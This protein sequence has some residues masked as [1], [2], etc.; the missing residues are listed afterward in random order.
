MKR[1]I[2]F[3]AA[4]LLA[5]SAQANIIELWNTGV[6]STGTSL[7]DGATD[8]HYTLTTK[9]AGEAGTVTVLTSAG[10]FPI[11]PWL[12][13]STISAWIGLGSNAKNGTYIYETTFDLTGL[14]PSTASISGRWSTDNDGIKILLNGVDTGAP[15]TSFTQFS[16]GY[17]TFTISS[18]FQPGVNTLAF[19]VNN[20]NA[21]YP[22]GSPTGVRVE[23]H[24]TAAPVPEPTTVIA[25]ALLL[26][27]FG[28]ST[29]RIL[30]RKV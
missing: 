9:P 6:D 17:A 21:D 2:T 14:I 7:S 3:A 27:P 22:N 26:L 16:A 23:M 4:L 24:G 19:W 29:M 11:P 30:R 8:P 20:G 5:V 28:V 12:G 13:D 10:G 15:A 18:G 25:G 1:T